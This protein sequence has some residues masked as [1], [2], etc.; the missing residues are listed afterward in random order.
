MLELLFSYH[1]SINFSYECQCDL[2]LHLKV[3]ASYHAISCMQTIIACLIAS[4][5]SCLDFEM[6][7]SFE[8]VEAILFRR[9]MNC[10]HPSLCTVCTFYR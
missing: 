7:Q 8:N 6:L 5:I 10:S 2:S 9:K 1:L 4:L 3:I